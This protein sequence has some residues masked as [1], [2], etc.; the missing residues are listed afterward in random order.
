MND[1]REKLGFEVVHFGVNCDDDLEARK[2]AET[3]ARLFGLPIKDGKNSIYAGPLIELMKGSGRGKYGH[4][5][6]A[7]ND[8]QKA[9]R[10][11]ES[12]GCE[13]EPASVRYNSE[14]NLIFIY[15][16]NEIAGFAVHLLQR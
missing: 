15:L 2:E 12:L 8:V 13:F 3:F 5:A 4:I 10:Y 11:L 6:V 16:K 7:T 14:G 1:I 9:Q